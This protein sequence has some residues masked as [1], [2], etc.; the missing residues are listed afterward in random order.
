[1][2]HDAFARVDLAIADG[3]HAELQ[4]LGLALAARS[5]AVALRLGEPQRDSY[6]TIE[7]AASIA[8]LP[9]R[10]LYSLARNKPWAVSIGRT[11]RVKE[12]GFRAFLERRLT[13]RAASRPRTRRYIKAS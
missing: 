11:I 5:C 3:T 12:A 8:K 4:A 13:S 6:L 9:R 2:N 10:R 1:M 7:E